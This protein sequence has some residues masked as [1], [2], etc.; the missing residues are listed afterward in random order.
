MSYPL[1]PC[2]RFFRF[3]VVLVI[4][5]SFT[6]QGTDCL[7]FPVI[8]GF[9]APVTFSV[10]T[11]VVVVVVS[12]SCGFLILRTSPKD[13]QSSS[14]SSISHFGNSASRSSFT[15]IGS[16]DHPQRAVYT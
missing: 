3:A 16:V 15:F 1:L 12:G 10:I 14:T 5:V 13:H 7:T 11:S 9:I 8:T 2:A 6:L 4:R